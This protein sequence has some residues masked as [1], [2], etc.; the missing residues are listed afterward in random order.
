MSILAKGI[1][2]CCFL[3]GE[4]KVKEP[5]ASLEDNGSNRNLRWL[6]RWA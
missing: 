2:N 3:P 6:L 1:V 4:D 5:E